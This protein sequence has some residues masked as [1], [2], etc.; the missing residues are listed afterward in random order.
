[1][2]ILS[3]KNNAYRSCKKENIS[4][5]SFKANMYGAE[6]HLLNLYMAD[7]KKYKRINR[8]KEQELARRIHRGGEDGQKARM[9]LMTAN[10]RLA[11]GRAVL[12]KKNTDIPIMD[13]IQE[14]NLG[15]YKATEK[16]NGS[17]AFSTY[18]TQWIDMFM[19][20][21]E[22]TKYSFIKQPSNTGYFMNR[23]LNAQQELRNAGIEPT[24]EEISKK[25]NF[26]VTVIKRILASKDAIISL[27]KKLDEEDSG[28]DEAQAFI[29][30]DKSENQAE[31]LDRKN[32]ENALKKYMNRLNENSRQQI[33]LLYGLFGLP[34]LSLTEIAQ[35]YNSTYQ[36]VQH[37]IKK[38]MKRLRILCST[39]EEMKEF[40]KN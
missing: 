33:I 4:K 8:E 34:Q 12:M 5:S 19:K 1:M 15:L 27:N 10:L 38:G 7:I 14:A 21:A 39:N 9:E 3:V 20:R 37:H 11:A 26:S 28:S 24:I 30:N 18:A 23:I 40:L 16:Y 31:I 22:Y 35:K 13:L 29:V 36:A 32:I 2:K 17:Y 25:T 6:S